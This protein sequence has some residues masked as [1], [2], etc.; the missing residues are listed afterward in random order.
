[1]L[2]NDNV[3]LVRTEGTFIAFPFTV[4]PPVQSSDQAATIEIK[5]DMVDQRLITVIRTL[6]GKRER[7]Q[8]TYEVVT[9]GTPNVV[10]WGPLEFTFESCSSNGYTEMTIVASFSLGLLNDAF[11]SR[12]FAPNNKGA[13]V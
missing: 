2:V 9:K 3:D 10:E 4:R 7:A 8:I 12:L 1:M 11:P 6:G 13:I 5:A